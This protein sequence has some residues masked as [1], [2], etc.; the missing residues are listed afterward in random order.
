[1]KKGKGEEGREN[2]EF[3]FVLFSKKD[4]G[5]EERAYKKRGGGWL[6]YQDTGIFMEGGFFVL[7]NKKLVR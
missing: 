4:K 6:L 7:S 3:A 1:M 5:N 2:S